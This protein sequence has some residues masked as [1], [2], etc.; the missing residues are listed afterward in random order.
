MKF[1]RIV[2]LTFVL[3]LLASLMLT[4]CAPKVNVV[5][6]EGADRDAV[7]EYAQPQVDALLAGLTAKDY[8]VFSAD[9]SDEMLKAIPE[10][11]FGK[12]YDQSIGATGAFTTV[13]LNRV[14]QVEGYYR[15]I[16]NV[17]TDKDMKL[18]L[19]VTITADE[20]HKVAGIF[21]QPAK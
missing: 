14:E 20:P 4:A 15:V 9:F 12:L 21:F 8:A 6:V 2:T 16:Y 19:L 10:S 7:M 17:Q 11:A 18:S 3:A 1:N 13:E 5:P